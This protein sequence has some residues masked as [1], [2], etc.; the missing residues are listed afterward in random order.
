MKAITVDNFDS[1]LDCFFEGVELFSIDLMAANPDVRFFASSAASGA[2][3]VVEVRAF[4][5]DGNTV[6]T[7]GLDEDADYEIS[8]FFNSVSLHSTEDEARMAADALILAWK[9]KWCL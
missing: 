5:W 1:F 4:T 7:A 2:H 8:A 9:H 3:A 6:F